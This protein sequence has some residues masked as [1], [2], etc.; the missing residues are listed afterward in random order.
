MLRQ[1][2]MKIAPTVS[3]N[4]KSGYGFIPVQCLTRLHARCWPGL[5]YPMEYQ[6]V[7][8]PF[9]SSLRLLAKLF[10]CGCET[11]GP[12]FLLVVKQRPQLLEAIHSSLSCGFQQ[13]CHFLPQ[14]KGEP[15]EVP[16][17]HKVFPSL[18]AAMELALMEEISCPNGVFSYS[19]TSPSY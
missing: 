14:P 7:K 17:Q 19:P 4:L 8:N 10:S 9:P 12:A 3:V 5:G 11:E 13:Y 2:L 1:F 18:L 15:R 6:L 16:E